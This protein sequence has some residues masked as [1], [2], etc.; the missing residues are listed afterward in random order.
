MR[1]PSRSLSRFASFAVVVVLPEP[2]RPTIRIGAGGLSMRRPSALASPAS[3]RT[4]S[5]WT[6]LTTCWPGVTDF[7]TAW[8]RGLLCHRLDEVARDGQR[9]V[10]LQQRHADL[11][12]RDADVLVAERAG[13]GQLAED[14][15]QPVGQVLEHGPRSYLPNADRAGGRNALTDGDPAHGRD[16]K[17]A[18]FR[19]RVADTPIAEHGQ[20]RRGLRR[21]GAAPAQP[22]RRRPSISTASARIRIAAASNT[23][24]SGSMSLPCSTIRRASAVIAMKIG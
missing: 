21:R 23:M 2:C 7:V 11:A 8:P 17:R 14:A 16:R 15:G 4:S 3:T 6:I 9:D 13:L 24:L 19:K 20:A 22:S 18:H 10:G 5:S 1:L 12:Q